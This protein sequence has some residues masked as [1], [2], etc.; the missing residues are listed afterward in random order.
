VLDILDQKVFVENA[1]ICLRWYNSLQP[2][3]F[4]EFRCHEVAR[5][6]SRL[7]ERRLGIECKVY[8]G[9][10][11]YSRDVILRF[12]LKFPYYVKGDK[13]LLYGLQD[14][15]L[16]MHSWFEVG[17]WIFDFHPCMY[18]DKSKGVCILHFAYLAP[19]EDV[20]NIYSAD[21]KLT[22]DLEGREKLHFVCAGKRV[23]TIVRDIPEINLHNL[24]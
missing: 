18:L 9:T 3:V 8:D 15:V 2:S 19:V 13:S 23:E 17:G 1:D 22:Y 21:A 11:I 6:F 20:E 5:I 24:K 16:Y 12:I 14:E 7:F 4:T 10:A